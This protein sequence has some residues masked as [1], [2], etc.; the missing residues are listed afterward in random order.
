MKRLLLI[1]LLL[2]GISAHA[3]L[4]KVELNVFGMD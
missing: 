4:H 2:A 1:A 3:E